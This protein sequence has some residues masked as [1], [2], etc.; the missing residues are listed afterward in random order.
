MKLNAVDTKHYT[1]EYWSVT[2]GQD[3][4]T[5][6]FVPIYGFVRNIALSMTVNSSFQFGEIVTGEVL[7]LGG[8]L[9]NV[10]DRNGDPVMGAGYVYMIQAVAPILNVFGYSEEYRYQISRQAI[11]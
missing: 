4:D 6:N 9:R 5:G 3:Q 7:A 11:A 1:G 8:H 10:I 2:N